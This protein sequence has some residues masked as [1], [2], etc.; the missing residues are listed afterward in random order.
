[1][2]LQRDGVK[3]LLVR[4]PAAV[5]DPALVVEQQPL[6]PR[7]HSD[8]DTLPGQ[9]RLVELRTARVGDRRVLRAAVGTAVVA[10]ANRRNGGAL[11]EAAQAVASCAR[12]PNRMRN[13][14]ARAFRTQPS[15][16][17][18]SWRTRVSHSS[19]NGA[20]RAVGGTAS[21]QAGPTP[22]QAGRQKQRGGRVM[23]SLD[24]WTHAVSTSADSAGLIRVNSAHASAPARQPAARSSAHQQIFCPQPAARGLRVPAHSSH[25]RECF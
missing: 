13:V 5:A 24:E 20:A 8:I 2:P 11:D 7:D 16:S 3:R 1:M 23:A 12:K 25:A 9:R 15:V 17:T 14:S 22:S 4:A 19:C 6:A 21:A 18:C 10:I